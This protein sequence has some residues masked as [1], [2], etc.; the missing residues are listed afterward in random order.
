[1]MA[2]T[3]ARREAIQEAQRLWHSNPVYLDTETTGTGPTAEVIEVGV[4]DSQG[5]VLFSSL[6]RPRGVIE[7]GAMRVHNI[8]P[9]LVADAPGWVEIWPRLRAVLAG[10]RVGAYN[11]DFDLRLI[12]QSLQRAFL[13]WD[14]EDGSFFCIMKLYARFAGEWDS[15]RGG[16]RW[17]TLDA[18]SRQ[19]ELPLLNTHRAVDDARLARALLQYMAGA[20]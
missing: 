10:K 4:V 18:A 20:K 1:M 3:L 14:L 9:E 15:R 2:D 16:Y 8:S 13:R 12:K 5:Q 19:A 11:S 7:P 6:M 17:H